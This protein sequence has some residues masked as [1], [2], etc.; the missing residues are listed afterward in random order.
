[1]EAASRLIRDAAPAIIVTTKIVEGVPK[2]LIVQE[3]SDWG[4]D[5]K[6]TAFL[7]VTAACG[8]WFSGL[9]PS[10]RRHRVRFKWFVPST[11]STTVNRPPD[12]L[13]DT[14]MAQLNAAPP[15]EKS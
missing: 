5:S 10:S 9:L 1:M 13:G 11:F 3:A 6:S 15:V 12:D 8:A 4:A 2:D 7:M 14:Q